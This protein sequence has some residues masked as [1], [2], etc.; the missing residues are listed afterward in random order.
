MTK[1]FTQIFCKQIVSEIQLQIFQNT[2]P[3]ILTFLAAEF[4][5]H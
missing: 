3:A 4:A 1:V 5:D 2:I